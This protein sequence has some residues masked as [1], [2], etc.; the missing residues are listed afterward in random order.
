MRAQARPAT[1]EAVSSWSQSDGRLTA[2]RIR[3]QYPDEADREAE[4]CNQAL[5]EKSVESTPV[6][7]HISSIHH[8]KFMIAFVGLLV[9][10]LNCTMLYLNDKSTLIT[11]WRIMGS[12]KVLMT[13]VACGASDGT[14]N[15]TGEHKH[16]SVDDLEGCLDRLLADGETSTPAFAWRTP[17]VIS[18]GLLPVR[19]RAPV[20]PGASSV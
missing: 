18:I 4:T 5:L 10:D 15:A 17:G 8:W 2:L 13:D 7:F 16:R 11:L 9:T 1:L 14:R 6:S 12:T 20:V 19:F 3:D